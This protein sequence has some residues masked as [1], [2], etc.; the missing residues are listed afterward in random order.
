M[1]A[2]AACDFVLGGAEPGNRLQDC[3]DPRDGEHGHDQHTGRH[4]E[5]AQ[6]LVVGRLEG[7]RDKRRDVLEHHV[8]EAGHDERER[9]P[10]HE[11]EVEQ[12]SE[13]ASRARHGRLGRVGDGLP[14]RD[15]ARGGIGVGRAECALG[16]PPVGPGGVVG[17]GVT[18]SDEAVHVEEE[19][20]ARDEA[21]DD[22]VPQAVFERVPE[23]GDQALRYENPEEGS[24][25]SEVGQAHEPVSPTEP[26]GQDPLDE[27]PP[28]DAGALEV[29]ESEPRQIVVTSRLDLGHLLSQEIG[30]LGSGQE[31]S[32]DRTTRE[33]EEALALHEG[34][35]DHPPEV[36]QHYDR[37]PEEQH[38]V[39]HDPV[40]V[41]PCRTERETAVG[42]DAE[43]GDEGHHADPDE[44]EVE[45]GSE[46]GPITI[47]RTRAADEVVVVQLEVV[48][49]ALGIH[50][51]SRTEVRVALIFLLF[52]LS[53]PLLPEV[54]LLTE[55]S[56]VSHGAFLDR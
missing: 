47:V 36:D 10:A 38:R 18:A 1:V 23:G 2:H 26:G 35:D 55:G 30:V 22:L 14:G 39:G 50:E 34:N 4:H 51:L 11:S 27:D 52:E 53:D 19:A 42:V 17:G 25:E 48:S 12:G 43:V 20:R 45:D 29:E 41:V 7:R 31:G 56:V 32:R 5:P 13:E 54:E 33:D 49:L 6:V 8:R 46:L 3:D 21:E 44:D 28:H 9:E 24:P 37:Q 15:D 16:P 40:E